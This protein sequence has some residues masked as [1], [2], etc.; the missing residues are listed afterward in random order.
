MQRSIAEHQQQ[1]H[2]RA[3][4]LEAQSEASLAGILV[5]CAAGDGQLLNWNQR[6]QSL[7]GFTD[8]EMQ[9]QPDQSLLQKAAEQLVDSDAFL[10][11]VRYYYSH[12][13]AIGQDEIKLTDG[14]VP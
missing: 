8:K 6:F 12:P 5:V 14:R 10:Q 11:A 2:A 13:N 1:L 4:L 7:W 3:V 9:E